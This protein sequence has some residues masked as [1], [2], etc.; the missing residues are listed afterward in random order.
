YRE[1]RAHNP[2]QAES[3]PSTAHMLDPRFK[4]LKFLPDGIRE[5]A[6][7]RLTQLVCEDG[8]VEQLGATGEEEIFIGDNVGVE[9]AEKSCKRARL[10]SDFEEPGGHSLAKLSRSYL[11]IPATSTPGEHMFSLAKVDIVIEEDSDIPLSA[12][13]TLAG[14]SDCIATPEMLHMW[15][16]LEMM[17]TVY[18]SRRNQTRKRMPTGSLASPRWTSACLE[19]LAKAA[20]LTQPPIPDE[21]I[22]PVRKE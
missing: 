21:C 13:Y 7:A 15:S 10:E 17:S 22:T 9:L 2:L 14:S 19:G 11:A 4:H 8:E 1:E 16:N 18:E 6:Q 20:H 3:I 12:L 5:D